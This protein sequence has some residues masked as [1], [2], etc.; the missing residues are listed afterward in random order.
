[1]KSLIDKFL[2][3][4]ITAS[5]LDE[6]QKWLQKPKHQVEF[7]TY[8]HDLSDTN[9]VL[10]D[11]DFELAYAA[12]WKSIQKTQNPVKRLYKGWIKYAAI[13]FL[14]LG[15]G[16]FY[17]QGFFNEKLE[18]ITDETQITLQL[19]NGTIK[20]INEDGSTKVVDTRGEVIGKQEGSQ[21]SYDD[22]SNAETL[23]YNTLTVPYGKR[24]D[25]KL[26]DGT[27]VHLNAGTSLKYPVKFIKGLD[28]QVFLN[29]EAYFDVVKDTN[30]PFIVNAD[31]INVRVLGT[32]FN[33]TSY[34]EDA[35]TNTVLVEGSVSIYKKDETYNKE[36]TTVLQPGYIA[37]LN[38]DH[39]IIS[40]N[41]ADIAMHTAWMKGRL[42]LNEVAFKDI[43][44]K[45]ERQ[46]NVT[47]INNY[48]ALENR[49]FTAKFDIE[50][51]QQV[52]TSFSNS[53]SF[54][55]IFNNNEIIINP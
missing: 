23:A 11:I 26:S 36:T 32:Q 20:V 18:P 3:N 28:R 27:L 5:E 43:L 2:N 16:Y 13:A 42:I 40:I 17:Q 12:V 35:H 41:Q 30:H 22:N 45:L 1:M 37:S 51:I 7:E 34:P 47:F 25:V 31:E 52:M 15:L 49:Y 48:K 38:K 8:L 10:Q 53:A 14:F 55:F 4:T 9:T 6:L 19:D 50:D 54:S 21:L 44:K 46:Y 33:M 29:G 39:D 24:F